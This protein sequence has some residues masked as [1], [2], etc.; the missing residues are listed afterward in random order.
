MKVK[1]SIFLRK[2]KMFFLFAFNK[3]ENNGNCNFDKNGENGLIEKIFKFYEKHDKKNLTIFDVGANIGNYSEVLMK[4]AKTRN[5]NININI[6]EPQAKCFEILNKKFGGISSIKLNNIGL[7][8]CQEK[9]KI[10]FD[11]EGSSLASVYKREI[12]TNEF[13]FNEDIFLTK[14]E[15]YISSNSIA[16]ID[17]IKLD[18]EGHELMA[19]EGFGKYLKSD[20]IDFIQFEYGG[21]N[22]DSNTNLKQMYEILEQRGFVLAKIMP[23]GVAIR[24][25]EHYMDNFQYSNYLAI[26]K[27]II[28]MI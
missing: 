17:F 3:L 20:F 4:H 22:L 1:K 15:N 26:S 18:I 23:N 12:S 11:K 9:T 10:F 13:N 5:I 14:A 7:S 16:H 2:L 21:A 8:N 24:K 6:F 25:Y 27:R 28:N 19:L